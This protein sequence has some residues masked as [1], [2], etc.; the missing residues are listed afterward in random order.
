MWKLGLWPRNSFPGNICFEFSVL[1]AVLLNPRI[2][3]RSCGNFVHL[4]CTY[5]IVALWKV[6]VLHPKS[7]A[8]QQWMKKGRRVVHVHAQYSDGKKWKD[9]WNQF[10]VG[11]SGRDSNYSML[12][13]KY[14]FLITILSPAIGVQTCLTAHALS[15]NFR[16]V[17]RGL[18]TE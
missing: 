10:T 8:A 1:V 5:T 14:L 16:T 17:N 3:G 15:W 7:I 12:L 18:G 13:F 9:T 4:P 11:Q 6:Q 2:V